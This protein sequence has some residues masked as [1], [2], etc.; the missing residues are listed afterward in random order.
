MQGL[1]FLL[2]FVLLYRGVQGPGLLYE[3]AYKGSGFIG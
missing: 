2:G 3:R 1:G